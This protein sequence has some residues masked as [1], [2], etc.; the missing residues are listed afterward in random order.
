MPHAKRAL[1]LF[2]TDVTSQV[3]LKETFGG[4]HQLVINGIN[5]DL[6]LIGEWELWQKEVL[7][8]KQNYDVIFLGLYQALRDR[9]GKSVN[10]VDEVARWTSVHSP[11]LIFGF[12]DWE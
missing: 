11:V 12:W 3:V 9:A 5:V 7:D 10:T 2:D 1:V 6:K 8:A 4:Q